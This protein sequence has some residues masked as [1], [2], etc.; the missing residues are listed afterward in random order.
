MGDHAPVCL[1]EWSLVL[2][3]D[4]E[5]D[6]LSA[7]AAWSRSNA[8]SDGLGLV[9]I[10][11]IEGLPCSSTTLGC[12][13]PIKGGCSSFLSSELHSTEVEGSNHVS[14][15]KMKGEMPTHRL[16]CLEQVTP[17][18]AAHV[19]PLRKKNVSWVFFLYLTIRTRCT[20]CR[21]FGW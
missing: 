7:R 20:C 21:G 8:N 11:R 15:N 5:L 12:V 1:V 9:D 17:T 6:G 19:E 2:S 16:H 10:Q 18:V 3:S 14:V 4:P 13:T